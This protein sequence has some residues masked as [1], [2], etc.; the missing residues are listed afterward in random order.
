MFLL[1]SVLMALGFLACS[2]LFYY[3]AANKLKHI[4]A[5]CIM[6][7]LL[8]ELFAAFV[9]GRLCVFGLFIAPVCRGNRF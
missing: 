2:F 9:L 7:Y 4:A 5:Y 6:M 3:F 1:V 8:S